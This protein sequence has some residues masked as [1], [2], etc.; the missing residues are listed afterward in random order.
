MSDSSTVVTS[1]ADG[2][3]SLYDAR[4][5]QVRGVR[6]PGSA[7]QKNVSYLAQGYT[8]LVPPDAANEIVVLS[9]DRPGHRYPM[10]PAGWL[11]EACA[12]AGRD[13]T[14]AEWD[15]YL[16]DRAYHHTCSGQ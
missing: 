10:D 11:K 2:M 6:L 5:G 4:R 8:Y 12:I 16:P 3:V 14:Q 15:R 7:G 9:G 13:L 1:G